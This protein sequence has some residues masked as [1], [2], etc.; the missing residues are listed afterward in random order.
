[1][2]Q[3]LENKS[4]ISRRIKILFITQFYISFIFIIV[5]FLY[6]LNINKIEKET[7]FISGAINSNAKLNYI[8]NSKE[9]NIYFGRI[10][11]DKI[12]L[13]YFVY[14]D[15]NEELLKLLP[16]KY[17][18]PELGKNGNICIL[19]HNYLDGN[20]FSDLNKLENDDEILIKGFN[21][22]TYIYKIYEKIEIN[23]SDVNKI[24]NPNKFGKI[25][26]LCTCTVNK[27]VRLIIRAELI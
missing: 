26:T 2:N 24:V 4:K 23:K 20:F 14:K 22:E 5:L 12:D 13:D 9:Y 3:I 8:F 11:I 19:G 10:I 27:D 6:W 21:N 16:C 15:C 7:E 25:L 18:G 1:M 17:S